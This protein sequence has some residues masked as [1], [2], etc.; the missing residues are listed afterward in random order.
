MGSP[1]SNA[2]AGRTRRVTGAVFLVGSAAADRQERTERREVAALACAAA[3]ALL[4][5]WCVEGIADLCG[6]VERDRDPAPSD[7]LAAVRSRDPGRAATNRVTS[8]SGPGAIRLDCSCVS[9]R[10]Y[11][12]RVGAVVAMAMG[13]QNDPRDS[14]RWAT[15]DDGESSITP[16]P[17]ARTS[18]IGRD[19]Q[20]QVASLARFTIRQ[21][22]L[23]C[24][25]VVGVAVAACATQPTQPTQPT[26]LPSDATFLQPD[27]P[28]C[29]GAAFERSRHR[30]PLL[31]S[32]GVLRHRRRF[33][34]FGG[35]RLPRALRA[36]RQCRQ[37]DAVWPGLRV[38]LLDDIIATG[39]PLIA[40]P[41]IADTENLS[42]IACQP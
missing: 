36:R 11:L 1:V 10:N 38:R 30:L 14:S 16:T 23:T 26:F 2:R 34:E 28:Q 17:W 27:V 22:K 4:V 41:W 21:A 35:G 42:S 39:A 24:C 32:A 37:R 15:C 7:R 33:E 20:E 40:G 31:P 29:F 6:D 19:P 8:L 25:L 12:D 5:A 9:N 13:M 18:P 3:S